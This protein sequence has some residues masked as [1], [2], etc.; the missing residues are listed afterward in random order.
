[1]SE[2]PEGISPGESRQA[3]GLVV[4]AREEAR[5]RT[6]EQSEVVK[7]E[8]LLAR[9]G[10]RWP[11]IAHAKAVTGLA[12]R[13]SGTPLVNRDLV[14]AGAMLHDIGRGTTHG[15][16]HA[17]RG[18]ALARSLGLD[19][20][21]ASIIE[22]HIGAGMTADECSLERIIPRDCLPVTIEEKIVANADNLV[23]GD[24]P[25]TIEGTLLGALRLKRRIR[26]RIY[27][28]YLEMESF[29]S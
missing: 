4:N 26:R 22:R 24:T 27:R 12:L 15:I 21:I 16:I 28:L 6:A 9:A 14:L 3:K 11:V 23:H 10:C 2:D 13:F 5:A 17:Q 25:G 20:R 8:A 1:M 18:A 19:E 7:W 29:R